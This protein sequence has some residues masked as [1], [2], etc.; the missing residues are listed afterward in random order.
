MKRNTIRPFSRGQ[1]GASTVD[2]IIW[3]VL[4]LAVVSAIAAMSVKAFGKNDQRIVIQDTVEMMQNIRSAYESRTYAGVTAAIVID[5]GLV[6][7]SM[8][9]GTSIQHTYGGAVT[10]TPIALFGISNNGIRYTFNSFPGSEQCSSFVRGIEKNV[11]VFVVGST[12][13][14]TSG[15]TLNMSTLGTA[16]SAANTV[17]MQIDAK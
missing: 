3:G 4:A 8:V 11:E 7:A 17:T 10:V 16:C 12:T 9:N 2:F 13:V 15:G 5:N 6:P 1:K 14:K